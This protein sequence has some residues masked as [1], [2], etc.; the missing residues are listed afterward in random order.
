MAKQKI[1]DLVYDLVKPIID[2][3]NLELV[4]VEYKKEGQHWYLRVYI[5]SEDGITLDNCELISGLLDPVLD[6]EDLI[7]DSYFLEVSSPGL[8]RALKKD[9]DFLRYIGREVEVTLYQPLNNTKN[10]RGINKGLK[11][12]YLSILL[13]D[14]KSFEIPMKQ[15]ASVKLY[16]EF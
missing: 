10:F 1:E 4:D 15:V 14:N 12:N 16:F 8:D 11:N 13:E 6:K 2:E 9:R 7:L 5:D 3:Q